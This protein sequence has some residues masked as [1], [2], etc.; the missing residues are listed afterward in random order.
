MIFKAVSEGEYCGAVP[1]HAIEFRV[2]RLRFDRHEL[3]GELTVTCGLAGARVFDEA[4]LS[5]AS[6]NF[7]SASAR[8]TRGKQLA[9]RARTGTKVDWIGLLEELCS[10]ILNAER[11]GQPAV[12][13]SRVE[14]SADERI[15]NVDGLPLYPEHQTILFGDGGGGKSLLA[16]YVG[17]KLEAF[18]ERVLFVDTELTASTQRRRLGQLFG[19]ERM[20]SVRYV[21]CERP[22]I[23]EVDR[24][25]R[26]ITD[27]EITYGIFDSIGFAC[28]GPPEAAESAIEY[29]RA[30][31]QLRIGGL[32][33]AHI[34][35]AE[36]GDQRPFGST[37]WH[38]GA[39]AT[40]FV[41]P[42]DVGPDSLA[43]GLINRKAN[44]GPLQPTLAFRFGFGDRR[45]TVEPV[46]AASVEALVDTLPLWARLKEALKTGPKTIAVL[47][48][49]LDA[50]P[51]SIEKTL[52]RKDRLFTRVPS[53]DGI[54]RY[55]LLEGRAA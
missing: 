33:V 1:E 6:M 51:D 39:R 18:G 16:L 55:G 45:I 14:T 19:D 47:A 3:H 25:R 37:F 31:R 34:S 53:S 12:V 8:A 44:I 35:K 54:T 4:C 2:S 21:R 28:S 11:R 26:I 48:S 32:H 13:L 5:S 17:G 46:S 50:K 41:K 38:N 15:A 10:L 42:A 20:P 43:I 7:S 22:L 40:W 30:M 29:Y 49:E 9:E 24:L 23:H 52:K 36:T 27:E